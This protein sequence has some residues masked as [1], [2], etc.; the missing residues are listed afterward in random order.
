MVLPRSSDLQSGS[1]SVAE[2]MV[3]RSPGDLGK[4][5]NVSRLIRPRSA[6]W[7][8]QLAGWSGYCLCSLIYLLLETP[9]G[10]AG[11]LVYSI[12]ISVECLIIAHLFRNFARSHRWE[13]LPLGP[14]IFRFAGSCIVLAGL[15]AFCTYLD[16]PLYA[17]FLGMPADWRFFNQ[18]PVLLIVFFLNG[19]FIFGLWASFYFGFHFIEQRRRAA[20]GRWQM[21]LE[22]SEARLAMLRQQVNPHFLFNA[23]NSVRTLIDEDPERAQQAITRLAALFR[24]SLLSD[25]RQTAPL[26]EELRIVD[27]YLDLELLRFDS[28]LTIKREIE[29]A[30]LFHEVPP[31]MLQ[32]LVENAI[33]HGVSKHEGPGYI[34]ITVRGVS[35]AQS[36]E[37]IIENSGALNTTDQGSTGTGIRNLQERLRCLYGSTASLILREEPPG[38][39]Q[40]T[41][42]IPD[43]SGEPKTKELE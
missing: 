27:D 14:M 6:Y 30:A 28:R 18:H 31:M 22:L 23:L 21:A 24:Y 8:C 36:L 26:A 34:A 19:F 9:Q 15:F 20:H 4:Q 11:A 41:V 32:T 17:Y 37:I 42:R 33:K 38:I 7:A 39:V 29:S 10:V 43:I 35:T 2:G 5:S 12:L 16:S 13:Q 3:P 40:A 1:T 25:S